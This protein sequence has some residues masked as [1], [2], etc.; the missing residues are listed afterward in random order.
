MK[1]DQALEAIKNGQ[2]LEGV[3]IEGLEQA[4]ISVRDALT[5]S[6]AGVVVPEQHIYYNDAEIEYDEDIDD[7]AWSEEYID[8]TMEEKA[9]YIEQQEAALKN[10]IPTS[11]SLSVRD[12]AVAQWLHTNRNRLSKVLEPLITNLYEA[13]RQWMEK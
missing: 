11:I 5:L 2:R 1:I 10:T 12:A 8:M 3:T 9:A 7:V 6:R 4:P 13:E